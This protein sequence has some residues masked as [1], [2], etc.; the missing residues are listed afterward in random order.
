[1]Q[2]SKTSST[3]NWCEGMSSK[4][5]INTV[6]PG[7][8]GKSVILGPPQQKVRQQQAQ[9]KAQWDW[10]GEGLDELRQS[11]QDHEGPSQDLRDAKGNPPTGIQLPLQGKPKGT[12][13][14]SK[15]CEG[16]KH[17]WSP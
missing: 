3:K 9:G 14:K 16:R 11:R 13:C 7:V 5:A 1:M 8:M 10:K 2:S 4:P 17:D 6:L 15:G 12:P